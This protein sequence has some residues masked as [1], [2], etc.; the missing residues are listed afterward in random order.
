[1]IGFELKNSQ[2]VVDSLIKHLLDYNQLNEYGW[3]IPRDVELMDEGDDAGYYRETYRVETP[4]WFMN[5]LIKSDYLK[6]NWELVYE[7]YKRRKATGIGCIGVTAKH[8]HGAKSIL[9]I[10]G[11]YD[12]VEIMQSIIHKFY[13]M[14]MKDNVEDIFIEFELF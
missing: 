7:T 12:N 6:P 3:F 14:N 9:S 4:I 5:L 8:A 10:T 11:Y 2:P 13:I 1:M